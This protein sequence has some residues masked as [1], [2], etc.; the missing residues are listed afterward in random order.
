M[1]SHIHRAR[2]WLTVRSVGRLVVKALLHPEVARNRALR[3]N[4][5][6]T[7]PLE[8]VAEFEKQTGDK[9]AVEHTPLQTVRELEKEAWDSGNPAATLFTLK[10]IWAS[11]GT[12]YE[13]RDNG[14]IEAEDTETLED[15]IKAT[16]AAQLS[17][18]L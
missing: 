4:S 12:L 5:F 11:G 10:R 15:A 1:R 6:T 17:A 7:T 13:T 3:V 14:L 9:W 8:I 18:K 2:R 16:V